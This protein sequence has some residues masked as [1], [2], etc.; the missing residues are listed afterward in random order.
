[1]RRKIKN[2]SLVIEYIG[3]LLVS[4]ISLGILILLGAIGNNE[5]QWYDIF[6]FTFMLLSFKY[7]IVI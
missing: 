1:M 7:L 5:V 2:T 4:C 3:L 6:I